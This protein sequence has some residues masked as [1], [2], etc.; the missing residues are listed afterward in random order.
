MAQRAS[1]GAVHRA[2]AVGVFAEKWGLAEINGR[3]VSLRP[4]DDSRHRN[5]VS[6]FFTPGPRFQFPGSK[7]RKP[8]GNLQRSQ[9]RVNAFR[10]P[11]AGENRTPTAIPALSAREVKVSLT[12]IVRDENAESRST[13]SRRRGGCSGCSLGLVAGPKRVGRDRSWGVPGMPRNRFLT[14]VDISPPF[15]SARLPSK[16]L[17]ST[18]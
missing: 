18:M 10:K 1:W 2:Q 17:C 13:P 5:G 12:M 16:A 14:H 3:K 6:E 8:G 11:D 15:D 4:F 9:S 7:A